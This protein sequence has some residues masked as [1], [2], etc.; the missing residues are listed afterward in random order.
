MARHLIV[1]GIARADD[2]KF[3]G[4]CLDDFGVD[5]ATLELAADIGIPFMTSGCP[6]CN[7]PFYNESPLGPMYN[8]PRKPTKEEIESIKKELDLAG[9]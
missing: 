9:R 8:F 4:G 1:G 7:R 6:N 3:Q 5:E 2:M